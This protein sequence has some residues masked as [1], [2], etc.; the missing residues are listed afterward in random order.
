MYLSVHIHVF[1][2]ETRKFWLFKKPAYK[3]KRGRLCFG[4]GPG[5]NGMN[6]RR[7]G[8]F[9]HGGQHRA[10]SRYATTYLLDYGHLDIDYYRGL[11]LFNRNCARLM[12]KL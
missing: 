10:S 6:M 2:P 9:E 8:Q 3:S 7:L 4:Y 5:H 1:D 12:C 11:A